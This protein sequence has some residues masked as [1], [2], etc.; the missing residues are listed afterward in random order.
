MKMLKAVLIVCLIAG[1][2]QAAAQVAPGD[3]P[4]VFLDCS[5]YC[6][7]PHIK[8]E[9]NWINWVNDAA[10]AQLHVLVTRQQTGAGGSDYTLNFIGLK[11]FQGKADTLKY[12][13]TNNDTEDIVRQG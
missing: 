6:D 4:R 10:D 11:E 9:I 5:Y 8:T 3:A 1:V 7:L 2:H 13:A 12:V